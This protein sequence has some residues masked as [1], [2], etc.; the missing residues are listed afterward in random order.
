M[1]CVILRHLFSDFWLKQEGRFLWRKKK[2][3]QRSWHAQRAALSKQ[4][5]SKLCKIPRISHVIFVSSHWDSLCWLQEKF[6]GTR[7]SVSLRVMLHLMVSRVRGWTAALH[8]ECGYELRAAVGSSRRSA[9]TWPD[10][11]SFFTFA[12]IS[13]PEAAL[14]WADF[15]DRC[16]LSMPQQRLCSES[17]GEFMFQVEDRLNG[18]FVGWS[19]C[20]T[21][22][23]YG[24]WRVNVLQV[25]LQTQSHVVYTALLFWSRSPW[26][27]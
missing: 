16:L 1:F 2:Y 21:H 10:I 13:V 23:T 9:S 24:P 11:L 3:L 18:V 19:R 15:T 20:R 26:E 27:V 25:V 7:R 4:V 6:Y 8:G 14:S 5:F 22:R 12:S 17:D